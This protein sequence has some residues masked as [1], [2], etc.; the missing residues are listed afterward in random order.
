MVKIENGLSVWDCVFV[1]R[2]PFPILPQNAN[3][4]AMADYFYMLF[5]NRPVYLVEGTELKEKGSAGEPLL[6][7]DVKIIKEYT[8]D[9]EYLKKIH[10][11]SYEGSD[12]E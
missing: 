6:D 1:N 7:K 4:D 10:T 8:D 12:K 9:Y 5:G 11:R 2:V 3:E